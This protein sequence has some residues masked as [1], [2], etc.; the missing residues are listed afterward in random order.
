MFEVVRGLIVAVL[1]GR[2]AEQHGLLVEEDVPAARAQ[3]QPQVA[4]VL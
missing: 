2:L 4:L 3:P 1:R